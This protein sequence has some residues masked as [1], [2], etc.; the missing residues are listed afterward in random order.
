MKSAL[1]TKCSLA[2]RVKK[3]LPAR[4]P[5]AVAPS[6]S[7]CP[8]LSLLLGHS[9]SAVVA[10]RPIKLSPSILRLQHKPHLQSS[11]P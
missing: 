1:W 7:L 9:N 11:L 2:I 3:P 8:S 4:Q 10:L 6:F 5:P